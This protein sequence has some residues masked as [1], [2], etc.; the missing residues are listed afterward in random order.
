MPWVTS[1]N[2]LPVQAAFR[3]P[4]STV[5]TVGM[6]ARLL[7]PLQQA[8]PET[9]SDKQAGDKHWLLSLQASFLQHD[10]YS[11][12]DSQQLALFPC[13]ADAAHAKLGTM[14]GNNLARFPPARVI[15]IY[16]NNINL[17][18]HQPLINTIQII[19]KVLPVIAL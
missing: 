1:T 10:V 13:M 8:V 18:W 17:G 6:L 12:T 9:A 7:F 4:T 2:Y 19:C 11:L 5:V 3:T 14:L 16:N 15:F